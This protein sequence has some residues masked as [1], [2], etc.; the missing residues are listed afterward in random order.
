MKKTFLKNALAIFSLAAA[1]AFS[2]CE[3]LHD[4]LSSEQ[5]LTLSSETG[6]ASLAGD[7]W[8]Y[9]GSSASDISARTD[10]TLKVNLSQAAAIG[11]SGVSVGM[12]T[13]YVNASGKTVT[14]SLTS[15]ACLDTAGTSLIV[16]MTPVVSLLNGAYSSSNTSGTTKDGTA[17]VSLSVSGLVCAAGKQ[18]GR[19]I[20][21]F[22][23]VVKVRPLW[24]GALQD[25]YMFST[26]RGTLGNSIVIPTEGTVDVSGASLSIGAASAIPG[27][28]TAGDFSISYDAE[29]KA[30]LL[31]PSVELYGQD[32]SADIVAA[33]LVPELNASA[34]TQTFSVTFAPG[35]LSTDTLSVSTT[36][37]NYDIANILISS[38]SSNVIV[39]VTF[40]GEPAFYQNDHIGISIHDASVSGDALSVTSATYGEVSTYVSAT[41]SR[42]FYDFDTPTHTPTQMTRVTAWGDKG[43]DWT[44][45]NGGSSKRVY[46]IPFSNIGIGV[47]S[48]ENLL[49]LVTVSSGWDD[50]VSILR[51]AC[52][53]SAVSASK[54]DNDNDTAAIDFSQGLACAAGESVA[55]GAYAPSSVSARAL[56]Y[57]QVG[58]Y[59]T[60][61][62]N[63]QSYNVYRSTDNA[64]WQIVASSLTATEYSDA[65]CSEKTT[66][67]YKVEAVTASGDTAS[68]T[69][70]AVTTPAY[71][72]YPLSFSIL[73]SSAG[74]DSVTLSGINSTNATDYTV[75]YKKSGDADYTTWSGSVSEGSAKITGLVMGAQYSFLVTAKNEYSDDDDSATFAQSSASCKPYPIIEL[76]GTLSDSEGWTKAS[77]AAT[78]SGSYL[79]SGD[80]WNITNVYVTNDSENLYLAVK[81]SAA[82]AVNNDDHN[83]NFS[84][85][86]GASDSTTSQTNEW[87]SP[88]T[89]TSY[90]NGGLNCSF[91]EEM[92]WQAGDA[93]TQSSCSSNLTSSSVY[94]P[95]WTNVSGYV[96]NSTVSEY[97]I[98]LSALGVSSGGEIK[99]FVSVSKYVYEDNKN[100][101]TV[102]DYL[103]A[104]AGTYSDS[105]Q[106]LAVDFSNALSYTIK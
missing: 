3:M 28:L 71:V 18:Y 55:V 42:E 34:V 48:A 56:A 45:K 80:V 19:T 9:N 17:S 63:A 68:K 92:K 54:T 59:W 79:D 78:S 46:T 52:P 90:S 26:A 44:Y 58:L 6:S 38:D 5:A 89:N 20:S 27:G 100:T 104:A 88:A 33:G 102:L 49:V 61:A 70:A 69:S 32:F 82:N 41:S 83:L 106:T 93:T 24:T 85:Y 53:A 10:Y 77:V 98:P 67:Y 74:Y 62:F 73:A 87:M 39:T 36:S 2:S 11:S 94:G 12:E 51:D 7:T 105:D 35:N 76:D 91:Y 84:F 16:D 14:V 65:T 23:K 86:T 8:Y 75:Q 1:L 43:D 50:N 25:G 99:L 37:T 47:D 95:S 66:Y 97:S 13:S 15:T 57:N 30:V 81:F 29:Q 60:R 72:I 101:E 21:A 4:S 22:K 96:A 31:T 40:N 103:P 64:S